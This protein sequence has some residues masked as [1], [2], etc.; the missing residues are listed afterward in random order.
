[1]SGGL[2][3]CS[4]SLRAALRPEGSTGLENGADRQGLLQGCPPGSV[5]GR[6]TTPLLG[7]SHKLCLCDLTSPFLA[8]SQQYLM[9]CARQSGSHGGFLLQAL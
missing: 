3:G 7:I 6:G 9:P 4:L 5:L 8:L 1:M 2:E